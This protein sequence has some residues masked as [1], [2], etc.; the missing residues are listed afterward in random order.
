MSSSTTNR[1]L[2]SKLYVKEYAQFNG[3]VQFMGSLL[4]AEGNAV[5]LN[6]ATGFWRSVDVV[7]LSNNIYYDKG[8][9]SIG[10]ELPEGGNS[11]E[12]SGNTS[13]DGLDTKGEIYTTLDK[14]PELAGV[15]PHQDEGEN[16]GVWGMFNKLFAQPPS[17]KAVNSFADAIEINITWEKAFNALKFNFNAAGIPTE[18]PY[19]RNIGVDIREEFGSVWET[20]T[21]TLPPTTTNYSIPVNTTFGSITTAA[22]QT[23]SV[24]VYGIND[25]INPLY[26][27]LVYN[28]LT[29]TTSGVPAEP[30]YISFSSSAFNSLTVVYDAPDTFDSNI[31][32][33]NVPPLSNYR[34]MYQVDNNASIVAIRHRGVA[35]LNLN[36]ITV[37]G[38]TTNLSFGATNISTVLTHV[39]PS[40]PIY[41][42]ATY[43]IVNISAKNTQNAGYSDNGIT[44]EETT[45]TGQVPVNYGG[46]VFPTL[47]GTTEANAAKQTTLTLGTS[48]TVRLLDGSTITYPYFNATSTPTTF[49]T[50]GLFSYFH[51]NRDVNKLGVNIE[52]ATV[53]VEYMNSNDIGTATWNPDRTLTINGFDAGN[54]N[55]TFTLT[56]NSNLVD[57][58]DVSSYSSVSGTDPTYKGYGLTTRFRFTPKPNI[59]DPLD[60][61]FNTSS[62]YSGIRYRINSASLTNETYTSIFLFDNLPPPIIE[63]DNAQ[64]SHNLTNTTAK[65]C[66]GVPSLNRTSI[67]I[68]YYQVQNYYG[69]QYIPSDGK[70]S[71]IRTFAPFNA[72][73]TNIINNTPTTTTQTIENTTIP[74]LYLT[75]NYD[76]ATIPA[77]GIVLRG[78]NLVGTD[79]ENIQNFVN[80]TIIHNDI[81]SYTSTN[82]ATLKSFGRDNNYVISPSTLYALTPMPDVEDS[83]YTL[84]YN[85]LLYYRDGFRGAATQIEGK[86]V[87]RDFNTNHFVAGRNYTSLKTTG[88]TVLGVVHKWVMKRV[89]IGITTTNITRRRNLTLTINGTVYSVLTSLPNGMRVY[90]LMVKNTGVNFPE[91]LYG[92][93]QPYSVWYNASLGFNGNAF[94]SGRASYTQT[95]GAIFTNA[96]TGI[97]EAVDSKNLILYVSAENTYDIYVLVG[98]PNNNENNLTAI[99]FS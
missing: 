37:E 69:T 15:L 57:F 67:F 3:N 20:I 53:V 94:A 62:I 90:L 50:N 5:N 11:F 48:R 12:V 59:T 70:V 63:F 17:Y 25:A 49:S 34:V 74:N 27:Y 21:T 6:D 65:W 92:Q 93:D 16:V 95:M 38:I 40:V 43:K 9:V 4:D 60:T 45:Q 33:A 85:H 36:A 80:T 52:P 87:Y 39:N 32:D 47:L 77:S 55:G 26:Q 23:Y 66:Y 88:D 73:T 64:Y 83:G 8:S 78:F 46:I 76:S 28:N 19:I 41:P 99:T 61:L 13:I 58:L 98:M 2:Y 42:N 18:L 22:G 29:F 30:S 91:L 84:P 31:P 1:N 10:R 81:N 54:Y 97:Y 68:R 35:D 79:T 86:D 75:Q 7:E 14:N 82:S 71:D 89:A 56:G 24:R 96:D 72:T 44:V 51:V